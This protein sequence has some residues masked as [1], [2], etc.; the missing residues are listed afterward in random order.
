MR[1]P[2]GLHLTRQKASVSPTNLPTD[3]YA[4]S[5][6]QDGIRG[7]FPVLRER[8]AGA[9]QRGITAD[10]DSIIRSGAVWACVTRIAQDISKLSLTL[11]EEDANGLSTEVRRAS[12]FLAVLK[13]PN[14]F[15]TRVKFIECWQLSRL[16]HGNAYV[17][18][19]RNNRGGA[20]KGTVDALYV[21]DPQRVKVL[22]S[23]DGFVFYRLAPDV[24]AGIAAE[25][26]VPESEIIHDVNV[27]LFHPLCGI[28]PIYACGLTATQGLRIQQ[29]SSALFENGS[30]PSGI[31]ITPGA[32]SPEQA[33]QYQDEWTRNYSGQ[34]NVGKVAVLGN[35]LKFE[36]MSMNAVD[37][38]L[39]DQLRWTGEQVCTCFH[40][41][42]YMVG[43]STT[44]PPY[45][46]LESINLQYY[47]QALQ[48]PIE[49]MELLLE[50]GLE[51]PSAYCIEVEIEGLARMNTA[52]KMET[53]V[54]GV[55]G[56]I[57]APN[58]ARQ[59]FNL[60]PVKGGETP[61][62]QQQN[63]S[64]EDLANRHQPL[65][66]AG[67]APAPSGGDRPALPPAEPEAQTDAVSGLSM[68][69]LRRTLQAGI[70][71]RMQEAA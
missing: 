25:V 45:T 12:P 18:K 55:G 31:L 26:V 41:P 22:V 47:A 48:Q 51:L 71:R 58:E 64:L 67:Q 13:K 40:V 33:K 2:F 50:E 34:R 62:L 32:I 60:P 56:G 8:F 61:Y 42:G 59:S 7:W 36:P 20:S 6:S 16:L 27:P 69:A 35:G 5:W 38:Q 4:D 57:F 65:P 3:A 15:Q 21:L 54:K 46:D 19:E 9:W 53:A 29:N 30:Q 66:L 28:S 70:V 52:S 1:L 49:N 17:L 10:Q 14:H 37:A 44:P 24:L 68:A 63:Y 23:P 11:L 43:V 39:I